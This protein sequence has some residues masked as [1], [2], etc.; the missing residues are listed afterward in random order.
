MS[1]AILAEGVEFTY[2]DGTHALRGIDLGIE[3]GEKVAIVGP[4]GAG[5]STFLF[6]LNGLVEAKGRIEVSGLALKKE[7]LKLI[8]SK[9]G[10]VFQNPDD[11]LFCPTVREDVAFG[12]QNLDLSQNEV[13]ARVARSLDALGIAG[14]ADRSSHHLS[15]GEKKKVA[16]AAVLALEPEIFAFDEPLANLDPRG[17]LDMLR[18]IEGLEQTVLIATHDLLVAKRLCDRIVGFRDGRIVFDVPAAD[19]RLP[20]LAADLFGADAFWRCKL[21]GEPGASDRGGSNPQDDTQR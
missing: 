17:Q 5:K 12:P 15:V 2:P 20:S 3:A 4:N 9:Y 11:Q 19:E 21:C 14:Y 18:I 6:A 1:A 16:I 10:L 7:N 8:R 13:D